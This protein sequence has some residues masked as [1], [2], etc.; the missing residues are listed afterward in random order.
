MTPTGEEEE[1]VLY[2]ALLKRPQ[3]ETRTDLRSLRESSS[4]FLR[5]RLVFTRDVAIFTFGLRF[6]F[7]FLFSEIGSCF[8]SPG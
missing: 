7:G 4:A 3:E 6:A 8:V 1:D 2:L 5:K